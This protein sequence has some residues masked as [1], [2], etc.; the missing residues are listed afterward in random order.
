MGYARGMA[1]YG[2][3]Y[4][5]PEQQPSMLCVERIERS[6]RAPCSCERITRY[7]ASNVR[8]ALLCVGMSTV[9]TCADSPQCSMLSTRR[10]GLEG[11]HRASAIR[12]SSF[13]VLK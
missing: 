1:T 9:A 4:V 7:C 5:D 13:C 6:S 12:C 3:Q 10:A 11:L 2:I 8:L